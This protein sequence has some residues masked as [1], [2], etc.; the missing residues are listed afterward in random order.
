MD[1]WAVFNFLAVM[2]KAAMNNLV[3]IFVNISWFPVD[4]NLGMGLLFD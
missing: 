4:K 1:T 2:N 3:Q